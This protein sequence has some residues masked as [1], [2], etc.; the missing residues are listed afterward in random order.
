MVFEQYLQAGEI[1]IGIAGSTAWPCCDFAYDARSGL[2]A[3]WWAG[4]DPGGH[5]ARIADIF[6]DD[7]TIILDSDMGAI[8]VFL[9]WQPDQQATLNRWKA[10]SDR[11]EI[12]RYLALALEQARAGGE[13][14]RPEA[15]QRSYET[16]VEYLP[17]PESDPIRW[18]P[19]LGW[20][21]GHDGVTVW[22][23]PGFAALAEARRLDLAAATAEPPEILR[24][25][26]ERSNGISNSRRPAG[27]MKAA[28]AA[29]A[30]R[31]VIEAAL[32]GA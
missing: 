6:Q 17:V 2:F 24:W 1:M 31:M 14:T 25:C 15:R 23:A 27:T 10:A 28:S 22:P 12:A 32:R 18:Q 5:V 30:A 29:E 8:E 3:W 20:A 4:E 13:Y 11:E 21:A 7:E 26:L 9:I 19:A 16:A